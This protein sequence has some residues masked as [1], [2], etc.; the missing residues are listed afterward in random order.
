M[1]SCIIQA[2]KSSDYTNVDNDD[3]EGEDEDDSENEEQ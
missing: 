2:T 3:D 1:Y